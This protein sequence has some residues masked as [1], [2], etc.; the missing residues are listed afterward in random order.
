MGMPL[1][2]F[3]S[4]RGRQPQHPTGLDIGSRQA[5]FGDRCIQHKTD[6]V[7]M[8]FIKLLV[9]KG[10]LVHQNLPFVNNVVLQL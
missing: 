3:S 2:S 9:R 5:M 6:T 7:E 4:Q 10:T 8:G 1:R